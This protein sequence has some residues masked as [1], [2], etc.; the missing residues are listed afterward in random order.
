MKTSLKILIALFILAVIGAFFLMQLTSVQGQKEEIR[1]T[2]S[3]NGADSKAL[4]LADELYKMDD[5]KLMSMKKEIESQKSF[6]F[7]PKSSQ[8]LELIS[9]NVALIDLVSVDKKLTQINNQINEEIFLDSCATLTKIETRNKLEAQFILFAEKNNQQGTELTKLKQN[10]QRHIDSFN[11]L[12]SG[13]EK[14]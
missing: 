10:Y 2:F 3:K 1:K 4:F 8:A 11:E 5:S 7:I 14:P 12:K 6:L 9:S 13:C